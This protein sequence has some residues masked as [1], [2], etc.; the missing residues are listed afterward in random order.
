M[1]KIS[2]MLNIKMHTGYMITDVQT[3]KKQISITIDHSHVA[4]DITAD[5]GSTNISWIQLSGATNH[6]NLSYLKHNATDH[7]KA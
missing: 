3:E 1:F 2:K 7:L 6:S 4:L 5:H